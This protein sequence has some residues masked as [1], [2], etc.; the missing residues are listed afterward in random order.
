MIGIIGR[1]LGMTQIFNE[2]GQQIP[3][4]VVEADGTALPPELDRC[5]TCART[6]DNGSPESARSTSVSSRASASAGPFAWIVDIE[7]S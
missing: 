2:A 5:T 4:T 3:V 6:A 1:K 7:P